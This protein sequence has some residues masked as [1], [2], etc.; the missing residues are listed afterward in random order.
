MSTS[1]D[2][3]RRFILCL[4]RGGRFAAALF[5]FHFTAKLGHHLLA[6]MGHEPHQS[7]H[8]DVSRTDPKGDVPTIHVWAPGVLL[9]LA[10]AHRRDN[11]F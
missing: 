5:L 7:D 11:P 1:S 10:P 3:A 6:P 4:F 9:S 8:G 2:L